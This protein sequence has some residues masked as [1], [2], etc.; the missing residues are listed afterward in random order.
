MHSTET[1]LQLLLSAAQA[2]EPSPAENNFAGRRAADR[3][4]AEDKPV[5]RRAA[6]HCLVDHILGSALAEGTPADHM[7]TAPADHTAA[8]A[9]VHR[10]AGSA[11]HTVAGHTF[12]DCTVAVLA[13][14][15]CRLVGQA[16]AG[17]KSAASLVVDLTPDSAVE[18]SCPSVAAR[19]P[20]AK[21]HRDCRIHF[22]HTDYSL[23]VTA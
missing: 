22:A 20:L 2:S 13:F 19:L 16:A 15:G 9:A 12:A 3:R 6:G 7:Q 18:C 11:A 17:C 4:L 10:S 8:G 5:G 21:A 1:L 23:T 14:V